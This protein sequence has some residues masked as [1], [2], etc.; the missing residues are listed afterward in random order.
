MNFLIS[1]PVLKAAA[2]TSEPFLDEFYNYLLVQESALSHTAAFFATSGWGRLF[3]TSSNFFVKGPKH[4]RWAQKS[5][6]FYIHWM[7]NMQK[8]LLLKVPY[9]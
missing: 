3:P 2:H 9:L 5:S 8:R 6:G 4:K 7:Y 1:S